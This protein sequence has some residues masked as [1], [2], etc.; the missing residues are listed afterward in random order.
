MNAFERLK[1]AD[2]KRRAA[3]A[4]LNDAWKVQQEKGAVEKS[5]SKALEE[6]RIR[7]AVDHR[8]VVVDEQGFVLIKATYERNEIR[9]GLSTLAAIVGK[10]IDAGALTIETVSQVVAAKVGEAKS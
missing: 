2:A 7:F 1:D 3:G 9:I 6:A 4:D 8:D 10:L 5:A